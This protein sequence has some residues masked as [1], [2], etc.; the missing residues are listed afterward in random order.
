ML[1]GRPEKGNRFLWTKRWVE[2]ERKCWIGK[3]EPIWRN[4]EKGYLR[5]NRVFL[6]KIQKVNRKILKIARIWRNSRKWVKIRVN[7]KWIKISPNRRETKWVR[8]TSQKTLICREASREREMSIPKSLRI[9]FKIIYYF[10]FSCLFSTKLQ[11]PLSILTNIV[12][13]HKKAKSNLLWTENRKEE[14][15]SRISTKKNFQIGFYSNTLF[16]RIWCFLN[17]NR[18]FCKFLSF[19]LSSLTTKK[20]FSSSL[21]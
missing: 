13:F 18:K 2:E 16:Y 20:P 17:K 14:G 7:P 8:K 19:C 3:K 6:K 11:E 15:F 4:R 9:N 1:K 10:Y 21:L 12:H 5:L